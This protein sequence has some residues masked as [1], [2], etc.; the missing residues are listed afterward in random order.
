M[1]EIKKDYRDNEKLRASFDELAQRTFGLSFE[2]W[3]RHGY[4]GDNYN[5]HSIVEDKRVVANVSVNRTD[6]LWNGQRKHLIQLGTVMT[7]ES[8]RGQGLCRRIMEA[9][10]EEWEGRADGLYL[11]ANGSAAGLYPRFGFE[12]AREYRYEKTVSIGKENTM[13]RV[14]LKT[15]RDFSRM[16]QAIKESAPQGRLSLVGNEGLFLFYVTKF[17]QDNI[18]YEKSLNAYAIAE[19]EEN[20]LTLYQVFCPD[21]LHTEDVV[22]AFG[23]EI[24]RVVLGY[25]PE[26]DA[27][28]RA[29]KLQEDDSCFFVKGKV[30]E[31]FEEEKLRFEELA[32]A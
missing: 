25:A 9:V 13:E 12:E 19:C 1:Y 27:G 23:K 22:E 2:D 32:R 28:C 26:W 10:L 24:S 30:F 4:W 15:D 8:Y 31:R 5:P 7:E 29:V 6:V 3:Y 18:Y 14:F 20:T 21:K 16:E 17:M 11:W